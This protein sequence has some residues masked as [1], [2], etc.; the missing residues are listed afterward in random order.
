MRFLWLDFLRGCAACYVVM[1]HS[2][3]SGYKIA[4][5]GWL[6]VDFFFVLSG[7]VLG[8]AVELATNAGKK[9]RILFLKNRI[10]RIGPMLIVA[11][12]LAF[13]VKVTEGIKEIIS[14]D[15]GN[16][17]AFT[18]LTPLYFLLSALLIQFL[19]PLSSTILVPLWS[20]SVEFY[21]N[22]L[23][24]LI[25]SS[26]SI[27]KLSIGI[28]SGILLIYGSG[29]LIDYQLDWTQSNTW[30][31]GFGR[32]F[33]GFTLGLFVWKLYTTKKQF[34]IKVNYFL[35]VLCSTACT[36]SWVCWR[37][38]IL[39][40]AWV[41]FSLTILVFARMKNPRFDGNLSKLFL[42]LGHT[43]YGVYLLHFP[44]L[45]LLTPLIKLSELHLFAFV[46]LC[47]L[48]FSYISET[49]VIPPLK[50]VFVKRLKF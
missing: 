2:L 49:Y 40:P 21:V 24:V 3:G 11:L 4:E 8:K 43:S 7:F 45:T 42:F 28:F 33:V 16:Q 31:F 36:I 37:S 15:V 26:G 18:F 47:T 35:L 13:A 6:S 10:L 29:I 50:N 48:F 14:G 5:P 9:S 23:T 12:L 38:Y 1:F 30:F 46:Y 41:L 19:Y 20:L 32:A 34:K 44:V 22:I 17:P 39:V 25:G 27:R